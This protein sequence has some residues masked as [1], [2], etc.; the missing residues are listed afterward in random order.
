[1]RSCHKPVTGTVLVKTK[2]IKGK[3]DT[4]TPK[5]IIPVKATKYVTLRGKTIWLTNP[6]DKELAFRYENAQ[7][8]IL[9]LNLYLEA[10]SIKEYNELFE[11]E[12]IS[13]STYIKSRGDVLKT[14]PAYT[15]KS[16]LDTIKIKQ[17]VF[18]LY[19]GAEV[20]T[21]KKFTEPDLKGTIYLQN[22]KGDLFSAG[23]DTRSN[24]YVGYTKRIF[25]IKR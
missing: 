17:P 24:I 18:T 19:G 9:K 5:E 13:I 10:I 15:I 1:M 6:V 14:A 22:K 3:F 21:T 4:I 12:Y 11:D 16:R 2:E 7:D 8:S 20:I 23:Y 25:E